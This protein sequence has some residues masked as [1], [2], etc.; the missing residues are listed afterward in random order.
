MKYSPSNSLRNGIYICNDPMYPLAARDLFRF[1]ITL[2]FF[3]GKPLKIELLNKKHLICLVT[4]YK[5]KKKEENLY[6]FVSDI[7]EWIEPPL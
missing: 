5:L 6:F 2:K 4:N 7:W 1:V 3:Y